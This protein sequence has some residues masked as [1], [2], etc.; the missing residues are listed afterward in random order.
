LTNKNRSLGHALALPFKPDSPRF[1]IL[2]VAENFG[3]LGELF[4]GAARG[5]IA[6]RQGDALGPMTLCVEVDHDDE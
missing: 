4:V 1:A 3:A 6:S 2:F 5:S